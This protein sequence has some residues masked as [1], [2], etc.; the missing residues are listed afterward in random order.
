MR[1][2]KNEQRVVVKQNVDGIVIN[3]EGV[4][5]RLCISHGAAWV[6]L[7]QRCG[8]GAAHPFPVG[9]NRA[10]HVKVYPED[11]ELPARTGKQRR[12]ARREKA[13]PSPTLATFGRDHWT[14]FLYLET[15]TVDYGGEADLRRMRCDASRH[16]AQANGVDAKGHATR[17]KGGVLLPDHDDWDCAEDLEREGLLTNEGTAANRVF[18]LT[19]AGRALA[20]V[21]RAHKA[22]G[23]SVDTFE[24]AERR[25]S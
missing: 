5:A 25:A 4:V 11:C 16:P 12:A 23:G 17:L 1:A 18:R 24:V 13:T 9:D 19:E 14:T 8:N 6:A 21:L 3:A 20:G 10:T 2:L 7:D 15:C 22:D